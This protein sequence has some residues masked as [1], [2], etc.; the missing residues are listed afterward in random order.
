MFNVAKG[1]VSS[2]ATKA[3]KVLIARLN[4]LSLTVY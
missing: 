4:V 2:M 3:T 1:F